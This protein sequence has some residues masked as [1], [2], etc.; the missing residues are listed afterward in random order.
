MSN[1]DGG[2][3]NGSEVPN[4]PTLAVPGKAASVAEQVETL[5]RSVLGVSQCARTDNFFELGGNS[6]L[7]TRLITRLRAALKWEVPLRFGFAF[8]TLGELTEAL[9]RHAPPSTA[10]RTNP[11]IAR[12]ANRQEYPLSF[13][14]ERFWFLDQL[15]PGPRYNNAF[16]LRLTGTL[17]V[18]ALERAL[19]EVVARHETLRAVF[20]SAEGRPVQSV[21]AHA[22]I[23]LG[24]RD[25]SDRPAAERED[26]A[27]KLAIEEGRR[28]F[29]LDRGPA[30][31]AQFLRLSAAEH[32]LLLTFHHIIVDGWSLGVLLRELSALY[33]AFLEG[34]SSLLP[35]LPIQ[36][37]DYALWQRQRWAKDLALAGQLA[38]WK[39][40]LQGAPELIEL[41][42]DRPR[43]AGQSYRGARL[44]VTVSRD[45]RD[46][47][48]ALGRDEGCTTYMVLLAAFQTL[49]ARYS[50]RT[51]ILVGSPVANRS[52]PETEPLI[53][54]FLN[55]LVMRGDLSGNPPFRQL[56]N[57]IRDVALSA[58]AHQDVPFEKLV[59]ELSPARALGHSPLF[60]VMLILQNNLPADTTKA[61]LAFQPFEVD[62]GIA[63]VDL[64]LDLKESDGGYAGWLEY[65]T[66]LFDRARMERL[67]GDFEALLSGIAARPNDRLLQLP[68][69]TVATPLLPALDLALGREGENG[70]GLGNGARASAGRAVL[71]VSPSD[72]ANRVTN[73]DQPLPRTPIESKLSAIWCEVLGIPKVGLHDSLFDLGGHSLLITMILSRIRK[74]FNLEMPIQRLFEA[75]T[76]AATAEWIEE[77]VRPELRA[78]CH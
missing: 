12:R 77:R 47:L 59:A 54:H 51:D 73:L 40:Q 64:T 60:Q 52:L 57:R 45:L 41:P 7:A 61:G 9:E 2:K 30:M 26:A 56:L 14:Q 32:I 11:T 53:G 49:L 48:A 31:R 34:R 13:A 19:N 36:Y 24:L 44:P 43:P 50:G 67:I 35:E 55:L 5:W 21:Q 65:A 28:P 38:Y 69:A 63:K 71:E 8:P 25:L 66:D 62:P 22:T 72:G 70:G 17:N 4:G 18:A 29:A 16:N 6:I 37:A 23:P 46:K 74:V 39:R 20:T 15:E 78:Q 33:E 68:L 1:G 10:A 58:Y 75:P 42:S 27:A 3:G 76:V